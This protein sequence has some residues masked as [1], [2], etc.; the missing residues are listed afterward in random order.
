[1][2]KY[3]KNKKFQKANSTKYYTSTLV[4]VLL[5]I[6]RIKTLSQRNKINVHIN[7][8]KEFFKALLDCT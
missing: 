8:A 2:F 1:M 4:P 6:S 3:N 7:F 5:T